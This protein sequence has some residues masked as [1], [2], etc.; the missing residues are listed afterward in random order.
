ML[1][2][3]ITL[4]QFHSNNLY[5]CYFCRDNRNIFSVCPFQ[6]YHPFVERKYLTHNEKQERKPYPRRRN[7]KFNV[8]RD[9]DMIQ[10]GFQYFKEFSPESQTDELL[11]ESHDSNYKND[12]ESK[13]FEIL[14]TTP[15]IFLQS[16]V[17][18]NPK[19]IN[20]SSSIFENE[21][22]DEHDL[23]ANDNECSRRFFSNTHQF[24]SS[25][26]GPEAS[27]Q[28]HP[29]EMKNEMKYGTTCSTSVLTEKFHCSEKESIG[30]APLLSHS[31]NHNENQIMFS[32]DYSRFMEKE[33][34]TTSNLNGDSNP[35][36]YNLLRPYAKKKNSKL[37]SFKSNNSYGKKIKK[38]DSYHSNHNRK[39]TYEEFIK[40]PI[41]WFEFERMKN[42][43][44]F[45]LENNA[46]N[47][48][49]NCNNITCQI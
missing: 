40:Y 45:F 24:S 44:K 46:E 11:T 1:R 25:I 12:R 28:S 30:A 26:E 17:A 32:V 4:P 48:I 47:V 22:E 10:R 33:Y 19:K 6:H 20:S 14:A 34:T 39:P 13:N 7:T 21:N 9:L 49:N 5:P 37:N 36:A 35:E 27:A 16:M 8:L 2:Q 38:I 42:F 29:D 15:S 18:T 3:R 23:T 43:K 41:F 31:T